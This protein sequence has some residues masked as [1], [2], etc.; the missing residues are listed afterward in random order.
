MTA[1]SKRGSGD[2]FFVAAILLAVVLALALRHSFAA[3]LAR[4]FAGVW[5]ATMDLVLRLVGPLFGG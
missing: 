3:G 2:L 4:Y 1:E 5:V